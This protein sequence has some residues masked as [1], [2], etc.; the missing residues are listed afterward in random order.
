MQGIQKGSQRVRVKA[1]RLRQ[2]RGRAEEGR[3]GGVEGESGEG[4][5]PGCSL[6]TWGQRGGGSQRGGGR[7]RCGRRGGE[8]RTCRGAR[9]PERREQED[10][11][12]GRTKG[13]RWKKEGKEGGQEGEGVERRERQRV[14]ETSRDRGQGG[15]AARAA[16]EEDGR[17]Q[18]HD[19]RHCGQRREEEEGRKE[20]E[21]EKGTAQRV[22]AAAAAAAAAASS[23]KKKE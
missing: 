16:A 9:L 21:R 1:L 14:S 22:R 20:R 4:C 17:G 11:I 6:W 13:G 18:R 8:L 3:R 15:P 7:R 19:G 12:G 23:E 2:E 10:R 5:S